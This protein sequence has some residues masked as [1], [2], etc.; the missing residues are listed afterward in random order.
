MVK[1]TEGI[2]L[3]TLKH[4]DTHLIVKMYTEQYGIQDFIIK[5]YASAT[6]RRKFSYFQPLS[7]IEIVYWEK[8]GQ[9]IHKIQE[10]RSVIFLKSIQTD[11]IKLVLALSI[12]EIYY[13]SVKEQEADQDLYHLLRSIILTM[14]TA[15]GKYIHY[16]LYFL[17]HFVKVSGFSPDVRIKN[18]EEPAFFDLPNG[19]ILTQQ[20]GNSRLCYL[21]VAFLN[22]NIEN[23]T[24]IVFSNEEKKQFISLIFQYYHY[25]IHGFR[26]PK[27]LQVFAEIFEN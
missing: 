1:K 4:Q 26:Q 6:S 18:W 21:Y 2:V 27:T 23:C 14:D 7:I 9:D 5:G 15:T 13:N 3:R 25:H 24:E 17:V 20:G 11:L 22:A 19:I 12:T 16:F 10:S 8:P